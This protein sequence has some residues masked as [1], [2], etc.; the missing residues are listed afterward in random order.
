MLFIHNGAD[1][2]GGS[3]SLL[4][5]SAQ[6]IADGHVVTV[7]IPY[8]GPLQDGLVDLGVDV[9][10]DAGIP[11]VDRRCFRSLRGAFGLGAAVVASFVRGLHLLRELRPDIVHTNTAVIFPSIG[12][13]ARL[14]GIPHV[15]HVRERVGEC[16]AAWK[17]YQ[18]LIAAASSQIVAVSHAM[19]DQ[20]APWVRKRTTVIHNG[21]PRDEFE[22]IDSS[23]ALTFRQSCDHG[24]GPLVGLVGRI[25]LK[26]KGQETFVQAA[27]KL[28]D[29]YPAARFVLIGSPFPGNEEHLIALEC[30]VTQCGAGD[31]IVMAGEVDDIKGAMSALDVLVLASGQPEPFGGVVVEA[32]A[33]GKPV[34]GTRLGG[35]LEQIEHGETGLLIA[36]NDPQAM[37]DAIGQLLEDKGLRQRLG[38]NGRERY[39]RDFEF[40]PFFQKMKS[41]YAGLAGQRKP[42]RAGSAWPTWP[43]GTCI[44]VVGVLLFLLFHLFGNTYS[45]IDV[46]DSSQSIFVWFARRW[47]DSA[48]SF[49]GNYSHGWLIPLVSLWLVWHQ[50]C[51][52]AA[53]IKKAS[54]WGLAVVAVGLIFH[55]VGARGELPQVSAVSLV[56]LFFGI[57]FYLLGWSTARLLVFPCAY[58]FFCLPLAFFNNMTFPLRMISTSLSTHLLNGLGIAATR[59][60][61]AIYSAAGGG[62][63]FDVADP[64][65]GIRSLLALMAVAALYAACGPLS[66]L[67]KWVLF[68]ASIPLAIAGNAARIVVVGIVAVIYGQETALGVYH[69]YSGFL[70]YASAIVLML[71]LERA[72]SLGH[73]VNRGRD[74][75]GSSSP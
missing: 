30:L 54:I 27:A 31:A 4:R 66:P 64:C 65:S 23:R 11:V 60:G 70:F 15:Q 26:R 57:P 45:G 28:R 55:W 32:M 51:E 73:R 12:F 34:V 48:L 58:L 44:A 69:D 16:G 38:E 75:A 47:N 37:A 61:T 42:T 13:A 50:R 67:R 62:F 56:V 17:V 43:T 5:L 41:L 18:Y 63:N 20:F 49:G 74:P 6:L 52:L 72:L 9:V 68:A 19:A 21:V 3:R 59:S 71:F 22:G 33:L 7:L 29:A 24:D 53:T 25:K 35:T 39:L 36:A 10:V 40:Q 2:Y 1:L 8:S 46:R 14:R